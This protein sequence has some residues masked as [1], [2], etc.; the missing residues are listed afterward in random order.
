MTAARANRLAL[1]EAY[2]LIPVRE[3]DRVFTLPTIQALLRQLARIAVKG[4]GPAMRMFIN[5]I[6]TI[7]Q[8]QAVEAQTKEPEGAESRTI[9]DEERAQALAVFM[10]KVRIKGLLKD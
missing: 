2:R 7:E 4:N 10:A 9:T 3:G 5:M 8:E 6:Q 1:Q